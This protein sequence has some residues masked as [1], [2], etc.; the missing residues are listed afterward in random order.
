MFNPL[1]RWQYFNGP[2]QNVC[3]YHD[4]IESTLNFNR[5]APSE[6]KCRYYCSFF[7]ARSNRTESL[8]DVTHDLRRMI[9]RFLSES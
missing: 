9:P 1:L 4:K 3:F 6:P 8:F 7:L 2:K 5:T